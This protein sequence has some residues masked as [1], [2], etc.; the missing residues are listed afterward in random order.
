MIEKMKKMIEIITIPTEGAVVLTK[1]VPS[2][3]DTEDVED[4][5]VAAVEEETVVS[6]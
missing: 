5:V 2:E 3:E 1:A 6:I 4:A